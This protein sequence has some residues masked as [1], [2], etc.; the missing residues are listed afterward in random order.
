M[1]KVRSANQFFGLKI[2][3]HGVGISCLAGAVFL[4]LL[5]FL[6][7]STQGAFMGVERNP[8]ILNTEIACA[9]FCAVY[10]A[11]LSISSIRSLLRT[12]T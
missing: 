9:V 5:V 1:A 11:Y 7:I 12:K 6:G 2:V 3:F 4:E 10:L 8:I